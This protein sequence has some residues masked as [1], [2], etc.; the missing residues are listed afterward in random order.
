VTRSL[1]GLSASALSDRQILGFVFVYLGID[2]GDGGPFYFTEKAGG[3]VGD[4][5]GSGS[6]T[7]ANTGLVGFGGLSN[8]AQTPEAVSW[9]ELRNVNT[10]QPGTAGAEGVWY[11]RMIDGILRGKPATV[12]RVWFASNGTIAGKW[13]L[14]DGFI[15]DISGGPTIR[16]SISPG[17]FP[18]LNW[19]PTMTIGPTCPYVYKG[20]NCGYTGGLA[21][22]RRT[23]TDCDNHGNTARFGGWQHLPKPGDKITWGAVITQVSGAPIGTNT[24]VPITPPGGPPPGPAGRE[25][26]AL[27]DNTQPVAGPVTRGG[28]P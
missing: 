1:G 19:L 10:G 6:H 3:F 17:K 18:W 11:S 21:S 12:W 8:D 27:P 5:D 15:D 22:C 20:A 23:F 25:P 4:V 28:T 24:G 13:K 16:V 26:I 7:W 9:V 2:A 14:I